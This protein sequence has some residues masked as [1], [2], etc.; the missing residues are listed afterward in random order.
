MANDIPRASV[1]THITS[2]N[3][4]LDFSAY[5]YYHYEQYAFDLYEE[6]A[7]YGLAL[8][9]PVLPSGLAV[10]LPNYPK[11]SIYKDVIKLW[12]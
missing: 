6:P 7:N 8:Y 9:D 1:V 4:V 11:P 2:Q 12:D 5:E 10:T 3:E